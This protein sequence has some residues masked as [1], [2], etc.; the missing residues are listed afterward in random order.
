VHID[1]YNDGS[2]K[3]NIKKITQTS[4]YAIFFMLLRKKWKSWGLM[5]RKT[6]QARRGKLQSQ[7]R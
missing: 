7:R 3:K 5:L 2:G 4:V 6:G 1:V